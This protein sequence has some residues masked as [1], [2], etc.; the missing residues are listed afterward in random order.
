MQ[1]SSYSQNTIQIFNW[2][3]HFKILFVFYS[4]FNNLILSK[5][6]NL[7][8]NL[9]MGRMWRLLVR[10]VNAFKRPTDPV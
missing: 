10:I 2:F 7:N 8:R 9:Q 5:P 1:F 4:R 6:I 3:N